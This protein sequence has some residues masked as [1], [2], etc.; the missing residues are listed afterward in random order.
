MCEF[1]TGSGGRK[2]KPEV[3]TEDYDVDGVNVTI[4]GSI[5]MMAAMILPSMVS[6]TVKT[7]RYGKDKGWQKYR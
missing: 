1:K 5:E 7:K 6:I 3:I 4:Y 2:G